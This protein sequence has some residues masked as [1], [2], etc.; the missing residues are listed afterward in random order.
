[1]KCVDN[2]KYCGNHRKLHKIKKSLNQYFYNNFS[3]NLLPFI[4]NNKKINF[5]FSPFNIKK[6]HM[7]QKNSKVEN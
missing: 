1:M 4:P 6:A 5:K 2:L 3:I 7:F